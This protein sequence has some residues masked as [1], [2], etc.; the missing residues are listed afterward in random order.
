MSIS[1]SKPKDNV[2]AKAKARHLIFPFFI[3]STGSLAAFRALIE[4]FQRTDQVINLYLDSDS[5][6]ELI[7]ALEDIRDRCWPT[8]KSTIGSITD[9]QIRFNS[10]YRLFG[11]TISG[12]EDATDFKVESYNQDFRATFEDILKQVVNGILDKAINEA[13]TDPD[14]LSRTLVSLQTG[15]KDHNNNLIPFVAT[16]W[17]DTF[18]KLLDLLDNNR[19]MQTLNVNTNGKDTPEERA[20]RLRRLGA[21]FNV[22][23]SPVAEQFFALSG[24]M[25]KFLK[26]VEDTSWSAKEAKKLYT[27]PIIREIIFAYGRATNREFFNEARMLR[28][29]VSA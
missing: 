5:D 6:V 24:N 9:E 4:S 17:S 27:D 28:I 13:A 11:W 2:T 29:R 10:Y 14:A 21:K 20:L 19:L 8:P 15:L 12:K 3:E 7:E 25:E 22:V 16:Y 18:E 23:I 1:E 26:T